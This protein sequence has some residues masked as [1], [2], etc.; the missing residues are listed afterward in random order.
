VFGTY[1]R[2]EESGS[3]YQGGVASGRG[4]RAEGG[5]MIDTLPIV[6]VCA[7]CEVQSGLSAVPRTFVSHGFCRRH[8]MAVLR[9]A[10]CSEAEIEAAVSEFS[11][12]SFCADLLK[13]T[14]E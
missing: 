5:A 11:E 10:G 1:V 7:A 4:G 8:F 6:R 2:V 9:H 13:G 3:A 12:E 14:N